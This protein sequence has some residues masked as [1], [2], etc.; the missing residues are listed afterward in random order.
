MGNCGPGVSAAKDGTNTTLRQKPSLGGDVCWLCVSKHLPD[1]I[2]NFSNF[3]A[4]YEGPMPPDADEGPAAAPCDGFSWRVISRSRAASGRNPA[5]MPPRI[6]GLLSNT[7]I[8]TRA[9]RR[10]S[11]P[12]H[13]VSF[14]SKIAKNVICC[15]EE[16]ST[17][18]AV[19]I[20]TFCLMLR[21]GG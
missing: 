2:E 21:G 4:A 19:G 7:S 13:I 14:A 11:E 12:S 8:S 20:G 16:N 10:S 18:S 17:N 3:G 6:S 9:H 5:V 1:Y 15:G